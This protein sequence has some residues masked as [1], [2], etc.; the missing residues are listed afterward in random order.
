MAIINTVNINQAQFTANRIN[1]DGDPAI[2]QVSTG[3][4]V[5]TPKNDSV[6]L[7]KPEGSHLA[8][9]QRQTFS[10]S[11]NKAAISIRTA[12]MTM[13]TIGKHVDRMKSQLDIIVKHYP[14]FLS[15]DPLRI[16]AL[17]TFSA[18]RKEIDALTVPPQDNGAA[19]I[20]ADP[21]VLPQAGTQK[22][23]L[24]TD[25]TGTIQAQQVH[26]GPTGINIPAL[27]DT[28]TDAEINAAINSLDA[29]QN[30]LGQR[31][32]GLSSDAANLLP[33]GKF[34]DLAAEHT[35]VVVG[36]S[37]AQEP[38]QGLSSMRPLLLQLA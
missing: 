22:F 4:N 18:F 30:T 32:E 2:R 34:A 6:T 33:T 29:A 20:M 16:R 1:T 14:P 36:K 24:G 25:G 27:S 13:K 9:G 19:K 17:R 26:T 35:S 7:Q 23:V 15:N 3:K 28:A 21:A 12:D 31:R 8:L 37:I 5:D 38:S 10:S 11:L